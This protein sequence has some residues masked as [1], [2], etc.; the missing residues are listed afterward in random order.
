[1]RTCIYIYRCILGIIY[2][3]IEY[4]VEKCRALEW[5]YEIVVVNKVIKFKDGISYA[6]KN[7]MNMYIHIYEYLV[8]HTIFLIFPSVLISL[9]I[10]R[11]VRVILQFKS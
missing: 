6:R 3:W 8:D 10:G 4:K 2:N 1:M 7:I 5:K 9:I 11:V